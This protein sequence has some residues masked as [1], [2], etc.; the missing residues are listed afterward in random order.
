LNLLNLAYLNLFARTFLAAFMEWRLGGSKEKRWRITGQRLAI[1]LIAVPMALSEA[2]PTPVQA[3]SIEYR[4]KA[5][6]LYNFSKFVEWPAQ[7]FPRR[8]LPLVICLVGDPFRG[9]LDEIVQGQTIDYRPVE[10]RR[11]ADAQVRG[12]HIVYVSPPE[13]QRSTEIIKAT[14]NM[15]ILTVGESED[16]I[17]K[18]GMIR[19]IEKDRRLHFQINPD[20]AERAS[21]K[22][23]SRLLQLADVVRPQQGLDI[24]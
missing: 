23:S 24:R 2:H 18:G 17:D 7:A 21:L 5:A 1:A 13:S 8:D 11:I 4:L 9:I 16:F 19:F 6:F 20:A 14:T 12:C 10:I 22:V 15:A 3:P